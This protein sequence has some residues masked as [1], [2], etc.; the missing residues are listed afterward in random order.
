MGWADIKKIAQRAVHDTFGLQ[1]E[2][3]P[4]NSSSWVLTNVRLHSKTVLMG[5]DGNAGYVERYDET[6]AM[7]FLDDN[8][9]PEEHALVKFEDGT[10]YRLIHETHKNDAGVAFWEVREYAE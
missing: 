6:P 3:Y 9:I 8:L 10:I 4:P 5:D 7:A 2:Y 1:V